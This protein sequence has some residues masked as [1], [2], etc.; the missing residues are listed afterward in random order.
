M[1]YV[2]ESTNNPLGWKPWGHQ[3]SN[4]GLSK[5]I[6]DQFVIPTQPSGNPL[7]QASYRFGG[8]GMASYGI[9]PATVPPPPAGYQYD[10]S[11]NLVPIPKPSATQQAESFLTQPLVLLGL[12]GAA[13]W[14]FSK[15]KTRMPRVALPVTAVKV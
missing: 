10:A 15:K 13:W 4:N 8:L 11:Y 9:D 3:L 5:Y 14:Y 2:R 7:N 12:A 1:A 6:G